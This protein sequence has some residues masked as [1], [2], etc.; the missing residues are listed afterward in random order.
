M[1]ILKVNTYM[2][3]NKEFRRR[4]KFKNIGMGLMILATV[5]LVVFDSIAIL[6]YGFSIIMFVVGLIFLSNY[7]CPY[8]GYIFNPRVSTEDLDY[9]NFCG[10]K[11]HE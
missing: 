3:K 8:C 4:I 10:G 6:K 7:R 5:P 1:G 11:L 9:C 2:K